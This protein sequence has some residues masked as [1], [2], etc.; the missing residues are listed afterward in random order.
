MYER[1]RFDSRTG[2]TYHSVV[3]YSTVDDYKHYRELFY[4]NGIKEISNIIL[5]MLTPLSIA[6]WFMDDGS[7]YYNSNNCHLTLAIDGF[8]E[9]SKEMIVKYFKDKYNIH[10]KIH[11]KR[12]RLT[13]VK[14]ILK[15]E[16]FFASLYHSSMEYKT[17]KY[18][19]QNFYDR[20]KR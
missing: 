5:E 9:E 2:N 1:S 6:V 7:L 3:I 19:K 14:E 10:F 11:Q 18:S 4:P 13:S 8:T 16:S 15:F 12:I 20:K 17:L